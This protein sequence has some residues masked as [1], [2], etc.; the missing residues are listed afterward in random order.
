MKRF[1]LILLVLLGVIF[2]SGCC[3]WDFCGGFV[4]P[5]PQCNLAVIAESPDI[6]GNVFAQSLL[7]GEVFIGGYINYFGVKQTIFYNIPCNQTIVVWIVDPCGSVSHRE[8]V[9]IKPGQNYLFFTYWDDW[10]GKDTKD[11]G[12]T[13]SSRDC[14]C[15]L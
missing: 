3:G 11:G 7:T 6:W 1:V 9:Y 15:R 13:N 5:A 10:Y 8:Y 2:L 14:H 4:I 12:E